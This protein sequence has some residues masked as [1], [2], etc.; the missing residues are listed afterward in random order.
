MNSIFDLLWQAI[1]AIR[2]W[3]GVEVKYELTLKGIKNIE[4]FS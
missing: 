4:K 3:F 1:E 2:I